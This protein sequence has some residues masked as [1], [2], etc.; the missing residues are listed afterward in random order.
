MSGYII[1]TLEVHDPGGIAEYAARVPAIVEQYGGRYLA[2][3]GDSERFE[4]DAPVGR[5]VLIEFES[6]EAA[7]RWYHSPEYSAIR[8]IRERCARGSLLVTDGLVPA[9]MIDE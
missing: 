4:G 7:R 9:V 6:V 1:A 3:G 8:P 5:V 2:R